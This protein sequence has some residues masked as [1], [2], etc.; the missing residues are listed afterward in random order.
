MNLYQLKIEIYVKIEV[1]IYIKMSEFSFSEPLSDAEM[2]ELLKKMKGEMKRLRRLTPASREIWDTEGSII[3]KHTFV[4]HAFRG[5]LDRVKFLISALA[6]DVREDWSSDVDVRVE[7]I[8]SLAINYH[9][10]EKIVYPSRDDHILRSVVSFLKKV[11][12]RNPRYVS[13]GRF[14]REMPLY[15][16]YLASSRDALHDEIGD[17]L[18]GIYGSLFLALPL[19]A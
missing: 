4:M 1:N 10:I 5:Q 11:I 2:A 9:K 19:H 17:D 7:N 3:E 13:D 8:L 12:N 16:M 14:I 6:I 15:G 18:Y